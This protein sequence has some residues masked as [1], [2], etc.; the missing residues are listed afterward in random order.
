MHRFSI[1]RDEK[2]D[3]VLRGASVSREHAYLILRRD[4]SIQFEDANSTNGSYLVEADKLIRISSIYLQPE[5]HLQLGKV[6]VSLA[7]IMQD[8]RS[9]IR[10]ERGIDS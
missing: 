8:I 1:G 4:Q 5:A 3:V 9:K 2:C 6:R 10:Q 7:E